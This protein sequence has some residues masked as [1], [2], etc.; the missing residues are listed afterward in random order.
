MRKLTYQEV[1]EFVE[2]LGYELISE[3][4]ISKIKLILKDYKGYY[5]TIKINNLKSGKTPNKFHK[6]NIY[7][8]Q[9]IK[10]W[11]K[12]NNKPFELVSNE[13]ISNSKKLKWKCLNKDC[14][15]EFNLN[16]NNISNQ[17][18][19]CPFCSGHQVCLSN[20][21]ATKN[22]ELASE[23]HYTLNGD[24]TPYDVT[25][26]SHNYVWW[27][28]KDNSKHIWKTSIANRNFRGDGCPECNKSKGEKKIDEVLINKDFIKINQNDFNQLI[29][30]DKYNKNY[31]IPQKE[32]NGLIGTG[33]GLLSYDFNIPKYNL[34]I[35]YQGR[36]HEKYIP[37]F[38]KSYDDFL[39]QLEHDRRKKEYANKHNI[40]L[41]EIWY[42]DF[43]NIEEILN[44]ELNSL[45]IMNIAI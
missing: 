8:I 29:D 26:N 36:Q 11:C 39:K 15:E 3:S 34:L 18:Q 30:K 9:N 14:G 20:C 27:Q 41:L 23:W 13:Y 6:L 22:P 43:D 4:Y 35:E 7:T 33:G 16:W 42:Y 2:N 37:G 28:C 32:F 45:D 25:A 12:I 38:H 44:K 19:G 17:N 40:R 5:Y 1:K 31:Y 10:L 21:L 24:L